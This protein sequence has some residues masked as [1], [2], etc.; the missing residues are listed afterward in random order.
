MKTALGALT[1]SFF[2]AGQRLDS[3]RPFG[4]T[5]FTNSAEKK[6]VDI[7][8]IEYDL[9]NGLHVILSPDKSA[10]VV[11]VDVWYHV[12]SK[13]E[14]PNRTGFAHLFEHMMFQGS[15]HVGKAEHMK[16]LEQAGGTFNGSTTWDRTNYFETLPSNR[17]ELAL[18]LESDRMLSLDISQE[19]L[20]NQREV[21]KEERRW[22]V[23]NRPYGT[24]WEKIFSLSYK[25]HPYH[26]PVVGYMQDLNA[27]SV[28][29]V[30]SFFRKYYAPNN[31]V[32]AIAGDFIVDNAKQLVEKYFADIPRGPEIKRPGIVEPP[33]AGQVR[34]TVYDDV[35]LPAVYMVFRIPSMTSGDA[36]PLNL[37]A[38]I[39]SQG[40]SSRLYQSLVYK[41]KIAQS[42]DAFSVDMEDP[43]V[44]VI[45]A[46]VS[47][48]H[49]PEEVENEIMAQLNNLAREVP[50]DKEL[51]KVKN[52]V[53]SQWVGQLS[54]AL[55][56]VDN[57][58]QFYTLYGNTGEA[59]NYLDKFL[60][61]TKE[62]VREVTGKY[63][64]PQNSVVVC[65]LPKNQNKFGE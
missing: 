15:A 59:N 17:L 27:A 22:R 51:E 33:L 62:Q 38:S 49:E 30:R 6:L 32:L 42:V 55:G 11:A 53:S 19:N 5:S 4:L 28:E 1:G 37:A 13:N 10:P 45:N 52:Q 58:A 61:V 12:G 60:S 7:K 35:A 54:K 24:A 40:E 21:V 43:G 20:D 36:E 23:D 64:T 48:G 9:P 31:A 39:L 63:L 29:D 47:P 26:W 46:V 65:Y 56:R 34:D 44:F 3:S 41:K 16:Y 25:I 18:W 14:E 8:F 2:S 57:L 50:G